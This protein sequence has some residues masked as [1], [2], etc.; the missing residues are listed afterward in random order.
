MMKISPFSLGSIRLVRSQEIPHFRN[1]GPIYEWVDRQTYLLID[2]V[3]FREKKGALLV[4]NNPPVH[5][6]ATPG[7]H[8]FLDGIEAVGREALGLEYLILYD[9]NDP[10]HAGGDL[11]ESLRNLEITLEKKKLKQA[12][13][14]TTREIDA[15]FGW[16]EERL[17]K[18]VTLYQKIR[19]LAQRLRVLAVCGGGMR[20]GGSAE[21]P[22]MADY[23]IGDSRGGMCFSEALIGII[24][25]WGGITRVLL[26][27]GRTNAAFMAMTAREIPADD[28]KAIG[29]YNEVVPVPFP[30][31]KRA[32]T[33]DPQKDAEQYQDALEDGNQRTGRLLLPRALELAVCPPA[34]IPT[35]M[36]AEKKDLATFEEIAAEVERRVDPLNYAP[37]WNRPLR[38]VREEIRK[39]GRPLAS[40][41]VAALEKLL[42]E[43]DPRSFVEQEFVNQELAADAA[44]Y[45]H[46]NFLEGLKA[47]LEQRVPDF[48]NSLTRMEDDLETTTARKYKIGEKK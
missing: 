1:L 12:A 40:Q 38:E 41:S 19:D 10:L 39:I 23:L 45:R 48:R 16:G 18:G 6:V 2:R 22:L 37:V 5:Q 11:K 35:L 31:P 42:A 25:G 44:L 33:A 15:L 29:V 27:A 4:Y 21:I 9:S 14:A 34:E 36:D 47:T 46:P 43:Y 24:P 7:L 17:R 28:L 20:F 3:S 13:G 32:R 8:A 26:K 30:F